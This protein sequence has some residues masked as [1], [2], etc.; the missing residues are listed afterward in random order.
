[1]QRYFDV[2]QSR[3][4]DAIVGG[5]VYVYISGTT[6]LATLYADNGITLQANPV[7]TNTD[8][9]YAFYAANGTYT[10]QITATNYATE[11]KPGVVL[12]DP[13]DAQTANQINFLQAG[14]GAVTRTA[15]SKLRDVVSAKDFGA[16]GDGATNDSSAIINYNAASGF[17]ITSA[18]I[19]NASSVASTSL[20]GPFY[21]IGQVKDSS[22]NKRAPN[23]SAIKSAPNAFGNSESVETAFNGD[24]SKCLFPIEY[25]VTGASTLTQPT[26]GYVYVPEASPYYTYFYN[27]SGWN[28]STSGN[29]GRTGATA[30]RTLVYQAGQ[31][32]CVAYNASGF[33]TG[34]RAGATSFLANPAASLFN[35]DMTAG[36][37]GVYLNPR[38]L[39]LNDNGFDVACIG[40][41]INLNR[42]TAIGGLNVYWAAYRSQSTGSQPVDV[43]FSAIGAYRF[44]IDLSFCNFGANQAAISLAANQR[45]YGNV[46]ATDSS[47]LSRYPSSVGTEYITY[48]S[49][50]NGW[51]FVVNNT[52]IFQLTSS[53]ATAAQL[54]RADAGIRINGAT[55][56]G[57][58]GLLSIGTTTNTSATAGTN[59]NVPAQVAGYLT[60]NLG[61]S[62]IKIPYYNA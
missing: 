58:A 42:T 30:F 19:Y 7:T 9:E 21:G 49:S 32:D 4:G 43:A 54:L 29:S 34:Q 17:K 45:I 28:Q 55:P 59:G 10:L 14:T 22:A 51:N 13:S 38:E 60:W 48:S 47:G 40:D 8:G 26:A 20:D 36:Q 44:G 3:T 15:Q 56:V 52:S 11:T 1:M 2:V 23:F 61:T 46:A 12:F 31:G 18:G 37:N 53:Q 6:T 39:A 33:V 35:G 5:I 50:L 57:V 16:V 62:V 25:R 27:A 24:L 41:V